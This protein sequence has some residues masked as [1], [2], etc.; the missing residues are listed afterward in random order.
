M[1][2]AKKKGPSDSEIA[3]AMQEKRQLVE[4]LVMEHNTGEGIVLHSQEFAITM[5]FASDVQIIV[6]PLKKGK[7]DS[8]RADYRKALVGLD[9]EEDLWKVQQVSEDAKLAFVLAAIKIEKDG[10][11]TPA[12]KEWIDDNLTEGDLTYLFQSIQAVNT[13]LPFVKKSEKEE[14]DGTTAPS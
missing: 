5:P 8:L 11:T 1:A 12:T 9:E 3:E 7:W 4:E 10:Q 2:D 6:A 13:A 14:G